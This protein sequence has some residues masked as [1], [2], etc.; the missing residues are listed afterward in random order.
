M[1]IR[2]TWM[3]ATWV[4]VMVMVGEET[5][6]L[7]A[8]EI[9]AL[10]VAVHPIVVNETGDIAGLGAILAV[11]H[12]P[13]A[14]EG[15]VVIGTVTVGD[16]TTVEGGMM[17]TV[18]EAPL[19]AT[20]AKVE[21]AP[22]SETVQCHQTVVGP[23]MMLGTSLMIPRQE[24]VSVG[25]SVPMMAMP[26]IVRRRRGMGKTLVAGA[27]EGAAAGIMEVV[28]A[29]GVRVAVVVRSRPRDVVVVGADRETD[30]ER[31]LS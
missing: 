27:M 23:M 26:W 28:D 21:A 17:T 30:I 22:V 19:V 20:A 13:T 18:A 31:L 8:W 12:V 25:A 29:S 14:A 6:T 7:V 5:A 15:I 9:G 2:M 3:I 16:M 4:V 11:D 1:D 24:G 10:L